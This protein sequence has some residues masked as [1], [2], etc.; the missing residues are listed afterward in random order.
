MFDLDMADVAVDASAV[1]VVVVLVAGG[2][3]VAMVEE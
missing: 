1:V 2:A 3:V